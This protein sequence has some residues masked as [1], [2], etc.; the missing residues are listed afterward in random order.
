MRQVK[1][2]GGIHVEP[3]IHDSR[4]MGPWVTGDVALLTLQSESGEDWFGVVVPKVRYV[5]TEPWEGRAIVF[6][7]R[8]VLSDEPLSL[9]TMFGSDIPRSTE[10]VA[11]LNQSMGYARSALIIDM[12]YGARV[13]VLGNWTDGEILWTK[14]DE[15][16]RQGWPWSAF[17]A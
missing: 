3:Q 11:L 10:F 15:S 14:L 7:A 12:S 17:T 4:L 9:E 2:V 13:A 5:V 1:F 6:E 8:Q 16:D